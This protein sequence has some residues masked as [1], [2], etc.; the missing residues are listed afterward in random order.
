MEYSI[1]SRLWIEND[2]GIFLGEGRVRLL[3]AI[4]SKGSLSKAAASMNMSYKKAWTLL[5]A[6]NAR[7]SEPVSINSVGGKGGG[8]V[9]IT[10]YGKKIVAEFDRINQECWKFLDQQLKTLEL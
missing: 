9:E 4:I 10:P 2:E 6:I 3:K 1:K 8:G 5:S 7:A